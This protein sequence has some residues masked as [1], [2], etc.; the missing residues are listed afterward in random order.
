MDH[1]V[2]KV[3]DSSRYFAVRIVDGKSGRST[4]VGIGFRER[5]DAFSFVSTLQDHTKFTRRQRQAQQ[6]H[7]SDAKRY[8]AAAASAEAEGLKPGDVPVADLLG[9]LSI[10]EGQSITIKVGGIGGGSGK[11]K[12]AKK[13]SGGGGGGGG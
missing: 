2:E 5:S 7:D 9:D 12:K 1:F 11:K 8:E 10:K 13:P 6:M 4:H 3:Q